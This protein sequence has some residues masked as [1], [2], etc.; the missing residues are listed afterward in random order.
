MY[1]EFAHMYDEM[2]DEIPYENGLSV[3]VIIWKCKVTKRTARYVNWGAVQV[4]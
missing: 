2:M 4:L 3:S 1:Q